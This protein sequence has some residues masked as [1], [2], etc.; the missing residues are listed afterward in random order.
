MPSITPISNKQNYL[1][2]QNKPN[3]DD[4]RTTIIK[5]MEEKIKKA[6]MVPAYNEVGSSLHYKERNGD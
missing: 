4:E 6:N 2:Y 1:L 3:V 5:Q